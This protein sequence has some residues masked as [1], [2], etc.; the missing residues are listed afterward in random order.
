MI[1]DNAKSIS[2]IAY[3][4]GYSSISNYILAFKKVYR[5]TPGKYK[6]QMDNLV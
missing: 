3:E 2:Q 4:I 6:K 1:A 5:I